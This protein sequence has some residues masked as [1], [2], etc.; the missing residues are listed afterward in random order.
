MVCCAEMNPYNSG[1]SHIF[2]INRYFKP[3]SQKTSELLPDSQ[4]ETMT[5]TSTI[6]TNP[7]EQQKKRQTLKN[8]NGEYQLLN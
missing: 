6:N 8:K 2:Q 7:Q 4:K 5:S 1:N 3:S